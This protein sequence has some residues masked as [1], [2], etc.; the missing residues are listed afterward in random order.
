MSIAAESAEQVVKITLDGAEYT[1]RIVGR[2]V[3][4]VAR[5]AAFIAALAKDTSKNSPGRK[6]LLQMIREG[7]PTQ[8]FEL[9]E[10][11]LKEFT[12][13]AKQYGVQFHAINTTPGMDNA[14]IDLMVREA[15][16]GKVN[17]IIER[18]QL[19][20]VESGKAETSQ[21]EA[22][23][24]VQEKTE[25]EK[26]IDA[27]IPTKEKTN[28]NPTAAKTAPADLSE[29]RSRGGTSEE[30]NDREKPSVRKKLN[31]V[32]KEQKQAQQERGKAEVQKTDRSQ[33]T[34]K[35]PGR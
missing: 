20:A 30:R 6:T 10:K 3:E 23:E 12:K 25:N 17:R 27:V 4:A 19:A 34:P 22:P 21:P 14:M 31:Q 11:D 26:L 32:Q 5:I 2:S 13:Q 16:A 28:E 8:F 1:L 15:D 29:P 7:V 33:P 18:F 35:A 9:P 24:L